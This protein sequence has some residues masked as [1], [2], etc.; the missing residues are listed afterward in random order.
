MEAL[1]VCDVVNTNCGCEGI[2]VAAAGVVVGCFETHRSWFFGWW[3]LE[4]VEMR[5]RAEFDN[6]RCASA[7]VGRL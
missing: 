7:F 1:T 5:S 4:D 2:D 3:C 6:A